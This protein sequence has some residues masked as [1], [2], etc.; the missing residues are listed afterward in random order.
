[1]RISDILLIATE[2]GMTVWSATVVATTLDTAV[3]DGLPL[4]LVVPPSTVSPPTNQNDNASGKTYK[5]APGPK[6]KIKIKIGQLQL[7]N[8]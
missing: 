2:K 1:M 7:A 4:R 3:C 8:F 6:L 5:G